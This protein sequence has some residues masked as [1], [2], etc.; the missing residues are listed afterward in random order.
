[1]R[2]ASKIDANQEQ[3][4]SALRGAGA[5]VQSLAMVGNGCPDLLVGYNGF[6]LLMEIKNPRMPPSQRKLRDTQENWHGKWTGSS[7]CIVDG[8]EAAL[9]MLKICR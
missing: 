6:T 5:F 1:M 4:V 2:R 9:R 8:P 7:L 3:I